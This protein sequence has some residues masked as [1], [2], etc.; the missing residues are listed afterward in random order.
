MPRRAVSP[1]GAHVFVGAGLAKGALRY[2]REVGAEAVQVF[3]SNPRGWAQAPG[4]PRQDELFVEG[5]LET[6]MPAFVHA[7]YLVNVGSPTPLTVERSVDAI[8]HSMRRGRAICARGVVVHAGTS[9]AGTS[10][11]GSYDVAM[12]Q[13]HENLLPLLDDLA[14]DDPDLLIEL[15]AGA[16]GSLAAS[17]D[18]IGAYLEAL[19][20]HPKV[21]FC[22]DTCH[23]MA[24]GHDIAAPGGLRS[25]LSAVAKAAGRDRLRLV[26]ANDSKDPVGSG[27]DRHERVGQGTIG[28]DTFGELFVH[29]AT[30]GVPILLETPGE[31]D[32]QLHD[33]ELL[34][35]LRHDALAR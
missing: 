17:P 12:K 5:C 33:L 15:T 8:R 9:V 29:P 25:F 28:A 26:H 7:P 30:R 11:A 13:V 10:V 1:V 4:D 3:V 18:Q 22:V 35:R 19:E 32:E 31:E 24:A 2:A 16:K 20:H 14:D 6:S 27:R 21:G 34:K 23:A